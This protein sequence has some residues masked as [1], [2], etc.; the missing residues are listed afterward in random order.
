LKCQRKKRKIGTNISEEPTASIFRAERQQVLPK[1]WYLSTRLHGI[2]AQ[3]TI[4]LIF[5]SENLQSHIMIINIFFNFK[6]KLES[7]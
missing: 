6:L 7:N 2:T 1:H 4:I 5:N 3:K